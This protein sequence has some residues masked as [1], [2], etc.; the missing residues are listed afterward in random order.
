MD[1]TID[2]F[3]A[4]H[5]LHPYIGFTLD[6]ASAPFPVDEFGFPNDLSPLSKA[7]PGALRV[8][9]TGGSVAMFLVVNYGHILRDEIAVRFGRP[10]Q[11]IELVNLAQ[12]GYKQPQQ[13]MTLNFLLMLGAKFDYL[14]NLDG[15]NEL[16]L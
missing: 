10:A 15:F 4:H 6:P 8:G 11:T 1:E 3:Y 14:I 16:A 12:G 5:V 7:G 2:Y 13:L 9:V